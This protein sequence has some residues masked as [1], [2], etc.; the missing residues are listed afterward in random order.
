M[1]AKEDDFYLSNISPLG[2]P[3]N[4]LKGTT[5]EFLKQKRIQENKAGSS[6]PKKF[7]ALSKEYDPHG[8][9]TAS[10]K[11]QDIKLEELEARKG[12]LSIDEFEKS[13]IKITEKSCLCVGLANA[14]YLENDIK[15]KG[16]AQ[17][18]VICPGP[19]LAYFDQEVSLKEMLHH[20]Y[21]GK[22]VIRTERPNLFIK[23]LKMYITYFRNEIQSI[24]GEL[25]TAQLKKWN[26][27]KSNLLDGIEYYKNLFESTK[28]F[29]GDLDQLDSC[30][31]ELVGIK[32][33]VSELV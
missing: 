10:K 1:N 6:C 23:E 5:N 29:K 26:S 4:T 28:V 20:I 25:T 18:V 11:Y 15:V 24:S 27:F 8:I 3:F 7:L 12:S 31:S 17:G 33:P 19:N 2:V 16:Q 14:S 9:C 32:I 13:K 22:S 30:K 21:H